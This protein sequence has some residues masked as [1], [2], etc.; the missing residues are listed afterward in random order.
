MES[1]EH[2]KHHHFWVCLLMAHYSCFSVANVAIE[3]Q[4]QQGTHLEKTITYKVVEGDT[5]ESISRRFSTTPHRVILLNKE[6]KLATPYLLVGDIINVPG[7]PALPSLDGNDFLHLKESS[8]KK[9][10]MEKKIAEQA[11]RLGHALAPHS[12][13]ND[14]NSVEGEPNRGV[15]ATRRHRIVDDNQSS[16][17]RPSYGTEQETQYW[18]Q[19]LTSQFQEEAN[20]YASSL[21]GTTGVARGRIT[22][23]DNFNIATAGAD[24]LLSLAED[25][26]GLLFTQF[27]LRRNDQSRT[28]ANLGIGQRHYLDQ[29]MVGYNLF[30]DYDLT[31]QHWRGGLGVETWRDY[32]K[33]G[34][35]FYT[36]ISDWHDSSRF[37]DMEE[38][39][40]RGIDVRFEAFLPSYPYWSASL[41][42]EQYFG[43]QVDLM[44]SEALESDP[45]SITA[46]LH[47]NPFPLL[48]ID[49]EQV[50]A[51]GGVNDTRFMMG[52][53]WRLGATLSDMMNSTKVDKSLMG[54]RHDLVERNNNI[55]LEY[56]D[57]VELKASLAEQNSGKEGQPLTLNLNIQHS[58][59]IATVQWF[60]DIFALSGLT[61]LDTVGQDKLSLTLPL[62]P[63]YF[64]DKPNQYPIFV[65]VTDIAGHEARAEGVVVVTEDSELKPSVQL[66]SD[67]VQLRAGAEYRIDWNAIDPRQNPVKLSGEQR[68]TTI[69]GDQGDI[70]VDKNGYRYTYRMIFEGPAKLLEGGVLVAPDGA[71]Q[72]RYP[73]EIEV[74][75][76][77]GHIVRDR[78]EFEFVDDE[79]I[80]PTLIVDDDN[81]NNKPTA[82]GKAKPGSTVSVTWPDGSSSTTTVDADGNYQLEAVNMQTSGSITVTV[83]DKAGNIGPATTLNYIDK[84]LPLPS[85]YTVSDVNGDNKPEISGNAE[86]GSVVN[87]TWPDGTSSIITADSAGNYYLEAPT[88]Q[89]TGSITIKVTDNAGNTGPATTTNYIVTTT[90]VKISGLFNGFPQVGSALTVLPDC[91]LSECPS[92]QSWQWQIEDEI[93]SGKFIDI[94]GANSITY[95]PVR[96]DQ[97]KRVRVVLI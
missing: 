33:L 87:I 25:N 90:G 64:V 2:H 69:Q 86:P 22:L 66:V 97:K 36:P 50:M 95:M 84:T 74:T 3:G 60:G 76:P 88:L 80:A 93:G 73:L 14:R 43:D 37:E 65:I 54:M 47:Y 46:G 71:I 62:L 23:D 11:A 44:G 51:K 1:H 38:R 27:G 67:F 8:P 56:R 13:L 28:I 18:R 92:D 55:V 19:Q 20:D 6:W 91:G 63:P 45:H 21:L 40:A 85:T 82:S 34:A 52:F 94:S 7:S 78:M 96:E 32:L 15:S 57:K 89:P 68:A 49:V 81:G 31:N 26:Q 30:A 35:N 72:G 16:T 5:L 42:A 79:A 17:D 10:D 24:M 59:Q 48:K 41:T 70:G 77:S 39:A 83:I 29:W 58:R 12:D 61:P 53:E 4:G 75:F 9:I